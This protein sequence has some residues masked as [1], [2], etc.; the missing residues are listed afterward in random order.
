MDIS[1]KLDMNVLLYL[2]RDCAM[3]RL[4]WGQT[5]DNF[6]RTP[7]L[8]ALPPDFHQNVSSLPWHPKHSTPPLK[9]KKI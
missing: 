3:D 9:E 4:H 2:P 8:A 7:S 6:H 5:A 1:S